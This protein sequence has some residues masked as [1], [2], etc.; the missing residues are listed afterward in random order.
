MNTPN[1]SLTPAVELH[2]EELVL[3]GF[4]PRDRFGISDALEQELAR[5]LTEQGLPGLAMQSRSIERLD[6]GS[7]SIRAGARPQSIGAQL[8][9]RVHRQLSP[10]TNMPPQRGG[11]KLR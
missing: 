3:H 11:P 5:L 7:L 4:S 8:G 10:A 6:G 1:T 2:I 9:E